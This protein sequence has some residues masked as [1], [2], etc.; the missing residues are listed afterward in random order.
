MQPRRLRIADSRLVN[1]WLV[2]RGVGRRLIVGGIFR[3]RRLLPLFIRLVFPLALL[4]SSRLVGNL[5]SHRL[6]GRKDVD[7]QRDKAAPEQERDDQKDNETTFHEML[8]PLRPVTRS[9]AN[10]YSGGSTWALTCRLANVRV[11]LPPRA[12][13]AS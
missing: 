13:L 12:F 9:A 1:N 11:I 4:F 6:V 2:G 3:V 7:A 10:P 8:H 5:F